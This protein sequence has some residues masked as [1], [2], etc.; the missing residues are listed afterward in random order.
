MT[1]RNFWPD[2]LEQHRDPLNRALH[3][4]ATAT[5]TALL[6]VG[7]LR[8]D[9]RALLAAPLVGYGVAW[10][11]H[12]LVERNRPKTFEAPLASL[13]ADYRL[14]GLALTGRLAQEYRRYGIPDRPGI[15]VRN[16]AIR[17]AIRPAVGSAEVRRTSPERSA[18]RYEAPS[19]YPP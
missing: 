17:A 19:S 7:L 6:A 9:R 1:D 14:M 4:T 5:A 8:R 15:T 18:Q 16:S 13:V 10:L 11:G 12:L 3:V 2:Y